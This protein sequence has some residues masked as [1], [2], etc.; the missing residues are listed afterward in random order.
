MV[1]FRG[2]ETI[3]ESLRLEQEIDDLSERIE[4]ARDIARAI[5][6][7]AE[8]GRLASLPAETREW[9]QRM[10]GRIG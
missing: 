1:Q 9:L 8:H 2:P 10:L 6:L 3:D 4:G 7:E 5:R